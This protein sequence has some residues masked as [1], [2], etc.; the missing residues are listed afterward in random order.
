MPADS[1]SFLFSW[2]AR[3]GEILLT[4]LA[5]SLCVISVYLGEL[6]SQQ[7]SRYGRFSTAS[8]SS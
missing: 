5:A 2:Q 6:V 4:V 7:R 1:E 3:I 8:F